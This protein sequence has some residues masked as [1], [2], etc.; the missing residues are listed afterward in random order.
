MSI[1]KYTAS[2]DTTITDAYQPLSTKRAYF[3]NMGAAD[4][5]EIFSIARSG[6]I[7]ERSRILLNFPIQEI[8]NNRNSS[9][10]PGSGSVNFYLKLSNVKHPDTLP[11]NYSVLVK[12]IS[13][14][15]DEGYGLDLD[16]YTDIGQS[17]SYSFGAN[18]K[19]R[20][21]NPWVSDGGDFYTGYDKTFYFDDGTEDL[22]IDVTNIIEDQMG[23]VIQPNGI[24]VMLSGSFES[25]STNTY[26]T[27]KFSARSSEY[28][29]KTPRLEAVWESL[30]K[31]DRGEFYFESPNLD[32]TDNTQNICFY[33]KVNGFLKDIPG[34]VIPYV[35][36]LDEN[37][38][39]LTS[40][41][42]TTK[43]SKG[44]YKASFKITGSVDTTL[45]DVWY[46]GSTAFYTGSL[47]VM[48]RR[49]D[50]NQNIS[51]YTFS[52][53]NLKSEYKNSEKA[54]IKIFS[55]PKN[56][57]PNIY[58]VA[59]NVVNSTIFKNLYY[60]I[61][62][63][64]DN[65]TVIDYGISPIAYTKCSYDVNGNYFNLD[66]SFM[67]PGYSYGIKLMILDGDNK[68]EIPNVY[69]FKVE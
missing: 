41:I 22:R 48:V 32:S 35:K 8:T 69:K 2:A 61:F 52:I 24:A 55:R 27:K 58:K 18:W 68:I 20:N 67:E 6:S 39:I 23:G 4:S 28:F 9:L 37:N 34:G 47:D 44:I 31:D 10:I 12:P 14:S 40:S 45:S 54:I 13:G 3:A 15:W 56:W 51:E 26:Y 59:N 36:L 57:S 19:Y 5:L 53:T 17:G 21:T 1:L 25:G 42:P 50:D 60:K 49:F 16:N 43:E 66:M 38:N 62:R 30:L 33:N 11:K 63:I 29:F 65:I 7:P 46:S 64:V